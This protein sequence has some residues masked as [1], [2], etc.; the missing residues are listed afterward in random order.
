MLLSRVN[1]AAIFPFYAKVS[2]RRIGHGESAQ[3]QIISIDS[4]FSTH[5]NVAQMID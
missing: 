1:Q 2:Q 5:T 4:L 3:L